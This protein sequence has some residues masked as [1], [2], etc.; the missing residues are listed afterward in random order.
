MNQDDNLIRANWGRYRGVLYGKS[1]MV[2]Y[3]D[4]VEI[5]HTGFRSDDIKTKEDLEKQLREMPKL[6]KAL[7][8]N[9]NKLLEN[10]EDEDI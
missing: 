10:D 1:S 2:I 7:K 8:E 3:E 6:M 4:G 5:F 9:W